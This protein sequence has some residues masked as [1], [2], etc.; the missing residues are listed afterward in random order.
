MSIGAILN[1]AQSGLDASQV[2]IQVTSHNIANVDTDGYTEQEVVVDEAQPTPT[3]VGLLG[4]GV[5][6]KQIKSYID[7]NLQNAINSKNSDVQEQ[8]TYE[9]NLTQIQSIFN[10]DNSQLSSSMTTFFNDWS[11]LSTDPTSTADKQTVASDGQ[12]LCTTFNTMYGDLS[13]LQSNLNGEVNDQIDDINTT[14]SQIASL[15]QLIAEN[16]TGTSEANDYIDQRNQLVQQ[17]AG[18]MNISTFTDGSDM[19]HV[20]TSNGSSLVNGVTSYQLTVDTN[21]QDSSNGMTQVGWQGP[22]GQ[23][24]DITSQISGGSLGA[25]LTTRDTTIPGYMSNLNGLAQ[26]IMQ[27]VNYFHKQGND[28]AGIPFFQS[29]TAN[30]AQGISLAS[31]IEDASGEVQ[32]QNV[33][34]SSST[35]DPTNNDV[36]T[37]IA[38]LGNDTLLG[39][40]TITSTVLPSA[41]SALSLSGNL[42]VNG[43]AVAIGPTDTL[44]DI[45]NNINAT[46]SAGV[47]A[48]VVPA[49]GGY[50]LVLTASAGES[51]VSLLNGSLDTS[52]GSFLVPLLSTVMADPATTAVG[53]AGSFSIDDQTIQV[54]AG[55]TL[56]DIATTINNDDFANAFAVV[57]T[58]NA[59][60][61]QLTLLNSSAGS[62]PTPAAWDQASPSASV[63]GGEPGTLALPGGVNITFAAGQSLKDV[64]NTINSDEATTGLF[65]TIT[66]DGS[67][68]YKLVLY[69]TANV[70]PASDTITQTL[71]LAGATYTDYEAGVVADV[72]QATENATNLA[73]YNQSALTS[74]QKQQSQESGVSIDDE[75]SNLIKFQNAYQAAARIYT[76]AQTMVNTLLSAVGVTTA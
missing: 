75:M 54:T 58:D 32:A 8:Q 36:A 61:Y 76:V 35:A 64:A 65:A 38:S 56:T 33:M 15:N 19:V 21:P 13:S 67:G 1:I 11:T 9:T 74:L 55:Q 29:T 25:L 12:S 46:P 28:N 37:A 44:T 60:G 26:S 20:L 51:N 31:Q 45:M 52:S 62:V 40:S 48:N 53:Q 70:I 14:T 68:K 7:Q 72:G 71:G 42:V 17:L 27:N 63:A 43:V 59:N 69:P 57:S 22:S 5:S 2:A 73:N 50:Q 6:V 66:P 24:I 34:A 30:Y 23:I 41:T 16:Q 47:S 39:G 18:Y 10:E 49:N 3:A 4:D